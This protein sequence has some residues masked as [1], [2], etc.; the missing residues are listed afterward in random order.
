MNF[1]SWLRFGLVAGALT[2]PVALHAQTWDTSGNGLLSGKY[3]FREVIVTASE[4]A[5]VYGNITFNGAGSYTTDAVGFD[6]NTATCANLPYQVS[7]TYS[8][9]ASGYGFFVNQLIGD[10]TYGLVGANGV[11]VASSTE[12]GAYDL[13]IAAPVSGQSAGTLQGTYSIAYLYPVSQ[14][15]FDALLGMTSNGNGSIGTVSVA[16]Y[17]TSSSPTT[18][19]IGGVK[20]IVSN[21]AF[22]VTFPNSSTAIVTGDEY[23][24]STP[25]GNFVFG[26]SPEDFDMLVGVRTSGGSSGGTSTSTPLNGSY[27]EAGM[28]I[29][30]SSLSV[31]GESFLDAFYGS[32]NAA[33]QTIVGHQRI[34]NGGATAYGYVYHD[35]F[36]PLSNNSYT[37]IARSRQF[38]VANGYRIGLGIGPY[39][40]IA[41]TRSPAFRSARR[42]QPRLLAAAPVLCS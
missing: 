14:E 7:G 34:Q 21:N 22:K 6:C 17:A 2:I 24:Y 18:Q 39:P 8:I 20:Y 37:D 32:F 15:P 35:A 29:D 42:K 19:N 31:T 12:S 27:Y 38:I 13:F 23:F 5:S 26:G 4:A 11:F 33:N 40:A 30:D 1:R 3:Y 9:A 41:V 28:D 36:G 25:D 16:A 10:N